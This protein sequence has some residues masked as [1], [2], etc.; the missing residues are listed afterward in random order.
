MNSKSWHS[1]WH[2]AGQATRKTEQ[3]EP[4]SS[5]PRIGISTSVLPEREQ[6]SFWRDYAANV[7]TSERL[8]DY[9]YDQAF[10]AKNDTY[11][12]SSITYSRHGVANPSS[13]D[14]TKI[15]ADNGGADVLAV[16]LRLSGTEIE[17]NFRS[18][19]MFFPGDIR[20]LDL[21]QPFFSA[22]T[23]YETIG[24]L[25]DKNEL[26]G[27]VPNLESLHGVTLRDS[28]MT[29]FLR[30]HLKTVFDTVPRLTRVEAEKLSDVT[31]ETLGASLLISMTPDA[32]ESDL[33]DAPAMRA[34]RHYIMRHMADPALSP[35]QIA[36]GVG[37]SRAK[38][39][40]LC[41]PYGTPMELVRSQRLRAARDLLQSR[42]AQSVEEA[43]YTVGYEN[44]SSFSRAFQKEFNMSARDCLHSCFLQ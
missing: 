36:L 32:V 38:L 40:R 15:H 17:H 10:S 28:A 30:I 34:I 26:Q 22:N 2:K 16:Q 9:R 24:V 20:I 42:K 21:T 19:R 3:K 12:T 39:F 6:F 29:D 23:H 43:A 41:K 35:N 37:M 8:G 31:M 11:F 25:V 44:R 33:M 7:G 1:N 27:H 14:R 4:L 18:N 5:L 13:I